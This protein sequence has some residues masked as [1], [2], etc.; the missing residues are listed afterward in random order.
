MNLARELEASGAVDP[1][2]TDGFESG[3]DS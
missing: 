3:S 1:E 2:D